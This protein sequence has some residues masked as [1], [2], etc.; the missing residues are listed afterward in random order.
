MQAGQLKTLCLLVG[1][2]ITV[3]WGVVVV[4]SVVAS[5]ASM[6]VGAAGTATMG[7][8]HMFQKGCDEPFKIV[9]EN[10]RCAKIRVSKLD[11]RVSKCVI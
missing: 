2:A 10:L 3:G 1:T 9:T 4:K 6:A 7:P 8:D 5:V 11:K